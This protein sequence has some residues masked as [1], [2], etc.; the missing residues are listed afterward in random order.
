MK[1]AAETIRRFI[2][3]AV[4]FLLTAVMMLI[5]KH[6]PDK[7]FPWYRDF[8][9]TIM[10]WISSVT[11]VVPFAI[12][13]F[14]EVI[15]ILM[16]IISFFVMIIRRRSFF[17]WLS[18]VTKVISILLFAVVAVWMLNHYAPP[19]ADEIGLE[20][21][22]YSQNELYEAAGYYTEKAAE[23][24]TLMERDAEGNLQRQDFYKL[25]AI[26]GKNYNYLKDRY[27][28]FDGADYPVKKL[29]LFGDY[30]LYKGFTGEFMPYTAEAS[31]PENDAIVDLPFF[32]CHEAA[33]RL[34]IAS[35]EEAN[36]AAYLAC[37]AS[38]DDRFRYA[39]YYCAYVHCYNA[40][41]PEYRKKLIEGKDSD[42]GYALLFKDAAYAARHYDTYDGRLSDIG[43][44]VN[45]K[46]LKSF[47]EES[48]VK[49]YGEVVD[50]LV[51]WYQERHAG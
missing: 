1:S 8:S 7:C 30:L 16:L 14:G 38:E 19:L 51:A 48:G 32:M 47:S 43:E 13:D 3:A 4:F 26:A 6:F 37:E 35:E 40:L 39:G 17:G 22:M 18:K 41:S 23:Y 33:H 9:R 25:A 24:A 28:I 20:K 11:R 45:D 46:Y 12:W 49:S 42:W 21:R 31:V 50:D 5:F 44:E 2:T 29:W 27:P 15:L 36:F 34:C 10:R